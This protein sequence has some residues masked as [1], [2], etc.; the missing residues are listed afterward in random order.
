MTGRL[1]DRVT[2][3]DPYQDSIESVDPDLD[4]D[5]AGQKRPTKVEKNFRV[6]VLKCW[7]ASFES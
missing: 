2:Y 4:P 3:P 1:L 5:P 6:H 7:M